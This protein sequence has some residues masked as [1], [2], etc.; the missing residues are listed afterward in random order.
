MTMTVDPPVVVDPDDDQ[1]DAAPAAKPKVLMTEDEK[2]TDLREWYAKSIEDTRR[3]DMSQTQFS[4]EF[5]MIRAGDIQVDRGYQRRINLTKARKLLKGWDPTAFEPIT[6][7]ERADGSLWTSEG[8][9]RSLVA[10]II[11]PDMLIPCYVHKGLTKETEAHQTGTIHRGRTGFS[12]LDLYRTDLAA[13]DAEAVSINK[14]VGEAG[15]TVGGPDGILA[16][17]ALRKI[18]AK[19]GAEGLATVLRIIDNAWGIGYPDDAYG[20]VAIGSIGEFV[21]KHTVVNDDDEDEALYDEEHLIRTLAALSPEALESQ[22]R[23]SK[24]H[25]TTLPKGIADLLAKHYNKAR[26]TGS[27]IKALK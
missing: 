15:L 6:V 18:H 12:N 13:G 10:Q 27:G 3:A 7:S 8:Q 22:A 23:N 25:Y 20:Y 5:R 1:D 19:I 26:P 17:G 16:V 9:H 11:N 4:G 14:V 21:T 24:Q 2:V